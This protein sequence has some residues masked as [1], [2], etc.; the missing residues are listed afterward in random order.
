MSDADFLRLKIITEKQLGRA[1]D[2]DEEHTLKMLY[3]FGKGVKLKTQLDA[4][5]ERLGPIAKRTLASID[6][7]RKVTLGRGCLQRYKRR[8]G[9]NRSQDERLS[10]WPAATREVP[11]MTFVEQK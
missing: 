10:E 8:R 3:Y 6:S 5:P 2:A 7:R 9:L 11:K 4:G 1:L